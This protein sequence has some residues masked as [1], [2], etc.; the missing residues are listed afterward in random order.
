MVSKKMT[1]LDDEIAATI[2]FFKGAKPQEI[3]SRL[4]KGYKENNQPPPGLMLLLEDITNSQATLWFCVGMALEAAGITV[5]MF[6]HIDS[7][8]IIDAIVAG[9]LAV[10]LWYYQKRRN[11]VREP[12]D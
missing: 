7:Y 10:G 3:P 6:M 5:Q 12:E 11:N 4:I 2:E 8:P 9:G 1:K